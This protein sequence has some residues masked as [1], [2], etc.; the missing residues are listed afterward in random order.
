MNEE[1][2][3]EAEQRDEHDRQVAKMF[4]NIVNWYDA[5]NHVLS[6]GRDRCWRK[7]L[8][9][10]VLLNIKDGEK[11]PLILDLAAGTLDVS[12]AIRRHFPE[13]EIP[14]FDF[15]LPMLQ[16]GQRKIK[17]RESIWPVQA[18]A[19][20]LPLPDNCVDGITMAFG[21]RNIADRHA[22]F[23]EMVRV[24]VPG[25]RACVLEFGSGKK[26]IWLGLYNFYLKYLLPMISRIF[27]N[28]RAYQ[29]L[30]D[31]ILAFPDAETI[32]EEMHAAGFHAVYHI[33]LSSGIV[34]LHVAE[35][36]LVADVMNEENLQE[37]IVP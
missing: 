13:A 5:L 37:K 9:E 4:G 11:S 17:K 16:R 21:I 26:R 10:M 14:A 7:C 6:F 27:S 12:L 33:P 34:Q 24:L 25:G 22:A 18:D 31:T 8:A 3:Q 1:K 30:R 23:A 19:L 36:A 28:A 20:A 15:C 29:Y 35:K 32:S 2:T